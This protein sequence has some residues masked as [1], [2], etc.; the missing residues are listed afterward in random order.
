MTIRSFLSLTAAI[1]ILVLGSAPASA[2]Q[3][4]HPT[5]TLAKP[6]GQSD[7]SIRLNDFFTDSDRAALQD[8]LT[9]VSSQLSNNL[10]RAQELGF[11]TDPKSARIPPKPLPFLLFHVG[12]KELQNFD[13]GKETSDLLIFTNQLLFPVEIKGKVTSSV[14]VR[15]LGKQDKAD[16]SDKETGW[17]ITRWGRPK[18]IHQLTEILP[19]DTQGFL[20]SI[21]SLNRKFLAYVKDADLKLVPVAPRP[22]F[23]ETAAVSAKKVFLDLVPEANTVDGSPR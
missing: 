8:N 1:S 13:P 10:L 4:A 7:F 6:N 21:P 5:L 9:A 12:L 16:R 22:P 3:T 14:T 18:L 20:V 23:K 2:D 11:G 15:F 19:P 17:R